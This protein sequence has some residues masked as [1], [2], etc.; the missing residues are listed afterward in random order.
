MGQV[1]VPDVLSSD[2][3]ITEISAG[4]AHNCAIY[5]LMLICWGSDVHNQVSGMKL[6]GRMKF[7]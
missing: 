7:A 2:K 6:Y 3:D 4:F 5:D 1:S